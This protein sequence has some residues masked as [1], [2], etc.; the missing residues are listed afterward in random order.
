MGVYTQDTC[1][2]TYYKTDPKS[3]LPPPSTRC[4]GW[5]KACPQ[6]R[7]TLPSCLVSRHCSASP[8]N[9][10][11]VPTSLGHQ[12]LLPGELRSC[13]SALAA[14]KAGKTASPGSVFHQEEGA[15]PLKR[16]KIFPLY[17][18]YSWHLLII[19]CHLRKVILSLNL[20][21]LLVLLCF[22]HHHSL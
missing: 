11:H 17:C 5:T 15:G 22:F 2:K 16:V 4:C 7:S 14:R 3:T 1:P 8:E 12:L 20:V 6:Y 9:E 19:F 21:T 18:L 10:P 13:A